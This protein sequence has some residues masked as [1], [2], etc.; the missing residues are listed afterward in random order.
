MAIKCNISKKSLTVN[1]SDDYVVKAKT[2]LDIIHSKPACY[3][4]FTYLGNRVVLNFTARGHKNLFENTVIES[5]RN[6]HV[7]F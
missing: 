1:V 5:Y 7:L 6:N 3:S 4:M 2:F